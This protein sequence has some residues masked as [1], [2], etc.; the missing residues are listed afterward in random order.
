MDN[1]PSSVRSE[2][3]LLSI[4]LATLIV[5]PTTED[6]SLMIVCVHTHRV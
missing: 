6:I 1:H 3:C 5:M 4:P 2:Y